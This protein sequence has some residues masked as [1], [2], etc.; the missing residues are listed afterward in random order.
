MSVLYAYSAVECQTPLLQLQY[1]EKEGKEIPHRKVVK[2]DYN[3][4]MPRA[5]P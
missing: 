5:Y 2:N 1:K 4:K 3:N